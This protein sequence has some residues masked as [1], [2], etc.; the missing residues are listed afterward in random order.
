[1]NSSAGETESDV[2]ERTPDTEDSESHTAMSALS[3]PNAVQIQSQQKLKKTRTYPPNIQQRMKDSQG[4]NKTQPKKVQIAALEVQNVKRAINRY[5]TLPKGARIGAYLESLRQHGLHAGGQ[6]DAVL[7]SELDVLK[8]VNSDMMYSDT[9]EIKN[10]HTNCVALT[11]NVNNISNNSIK[12]GSDMSRFF[13][14]GVL[15]RQK[16]DLTHT[17]SSEIFETGSIPETHHLA[18]KPVPSPRL[19]RNKKNDR[20]MLKSGKSMDENFKNVREVKDAVGESAAL[21]GVNLKHRDSVDDDR[22]MSNQSPPPFGCGLV[23]RT[24]KK[25]PKDRPPSPPKNTLVKSG[26]MDEQ[27]SRNNDKSP[28][29]NCASD[30]VQSPSTSSLGS[31][32]NSPQQIKECRQNH[33]F[34]SDSFPSSEMKENQNE[35]IQTTDFRQNLK[36]VSNSRYK[37]SVPVSPAA[38]PAN[39]AAQLVSELF[40]SLKMKARKKAVEVG[41][42]PAQMEATSKNN[43]DNV[44]KTSPLDQSAKLEVLD[45][46]S[47]ENT[48]CDKIDSVSI[49][50]NHVPEN[51][52][53]AERKRNIYSKPVLDRM[54][55]SLEEDKLKDPNT[56]Q[57]TSVLSDGQIQHE[58]ESPNLD[59]LNVVEND[60]EN[61]RHSSGSISSLKKL[62]EKESGG[63]SFEKPAD[64]IKKPCPKIMTQQLE[65]RMKRSFEMPDSN[66][67]Q[68]ISGAQ[69]D[70]GEVEKCG[71]ISWKSSP[72]LQAKS[73]QIKDSSF[74]GDNKKEEILS[75]FEISSDNTSDSIIPLGTLSKPQVPQKPPVKS[76]RP[77]VPPAAPAAKPSKPVLKPQLFPRSKL[78]GLD[79]P[80]SQSSM[81]KTV[82]K[83]DNEGDSPP[84]LANTKASILEISSA[85][86]NNIV[87]LRN[88]T[89]ISSMSIIQ[90][91]D[92][93]QLFR[94]SCAGYAEYIPPH[95]RF[96]FRELL[97]RLESQGEQLRT[98]NSNNSSDSAKLLS[99]LQNTVRD[100]VNLVQ[101]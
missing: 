8:E 54:C 94:T 41:P 96:R 18:P 82:E 101:R 74:N 29:S 97:S 91:T 67:D 62:W 86:E 73:N 9:I 57:R 2:Q 79:S 98:C 33:N 24:L 68:K 22:F 80:T 95:G 7:E 92:K 28:M 34:N 30:H 10:R 27:L 32:A 16:S 40:E 20:Y 17:K 60:D 99:E 52:N 11:S 35:S 88:A 76:C 14:H 47:V 49:T 66:S 42:S 83:N 90:L 31:N 53:E 36:P 65:S 93:V 37:T 69:S 84:D 100:V 63:H 72:P 51:N 25:R 39:P 23:R 75:K 71:R 1:M 50:Y 89:S 26:S 19:P 48:S 38:P 44:A 56:I 77:A 58:T 70:T 46:V 15:Q 55:A 6:P 12:Q 3:V 45:K 13:S 87:G 4:S 61:K 21:F 81:E 64:G 59:K 5:G 78:K 43:P 85:L